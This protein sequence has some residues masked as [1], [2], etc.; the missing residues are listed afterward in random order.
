[1]QFVKAHFGSRLSSMVMLHYGMFIKEG[2]G[3]YSVLW[4][5]FVVML[6]YLCVISWIMSISEVCCKD[7]EGMGL[8]L[9][10]LIG[11]VS[12]KHT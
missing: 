6:Y 9:F 12:F 4:H 8:F 11:V 5:S 7:L 2:F 10:F 1:M 3:A